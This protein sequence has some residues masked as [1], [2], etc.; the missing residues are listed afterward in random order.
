MISSRL[1]I[2]ASG[3]SM[4]GHCL[5]ATVSHALAPWGIPYGRSLKSARGPDGPSSAIYTCRLALELTVLEHQMIAAV[6]S[7]TPGMELHIPPGKVP[8]RK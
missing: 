4:S 1:Y 3:Q 7:W 8:S 2:V 5:A 6:P